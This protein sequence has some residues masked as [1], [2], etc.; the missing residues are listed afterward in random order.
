M[1]GANSTCR[2]ANARQISTFPGER[3]RHGAAELTVTAS[4]DGQPMGC[5]SAASSG[6]RLTLALP[7]AQ[8][9]LWEVG[10]GG[11]Y[12]LTLTYGEGAEF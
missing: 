5:V 9:H 11:L 6:G 8:R 2:F 12:A 10:R 7:L 1:Y 4:F 3:E